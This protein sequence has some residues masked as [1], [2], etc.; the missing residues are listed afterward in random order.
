MQ[1]TE[2]WRVEQA[3]MGRRSECVTCPVNGRNRTE[4]GD[5]FSYATLLYAAMSVA[6]KDA[7]HLQPEKL[8]QS[9]RLMSV[10]EKV[11]SAGR[12]STSSPD[13]VMTG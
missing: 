12:L 2:G 10:L 4:A 13:L 3:G 11:N 7:D 9:K 8:S 5:P 1:F 6:G